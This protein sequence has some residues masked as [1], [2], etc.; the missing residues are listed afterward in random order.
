MDPSVQVKAIDAQSVHRITSGQVVIDLQTA[1]KELVEN[2]LDAKAT[3]IEVRFKEYGLRSIEVIDNGTGIAPQNYDSVGLKHHTSKLASF[4]DLTSVMTFGF[5]GEAISSLCALTESVTVTTAIAGAKF[6]TVLELDKDGSVRS[7]S[8]KVARQRGTTVSV[9]ELFKPLPVRRKELER[10]AKREF[11]KALHLLNAYA[12]VPCTKENQGVVFTVTNVTQGRKAVQLRTDGTMSLAA[13]V[14]SL[15]GP[16]TMENLVDLDLTFDVVTEAS[17]LR[18]RGPDSNVAA[19]NTIHVK[20]LISKFTVGGGRTGTDRQFFFI[21]GRPCNPTKVQKAFNEVYRTF[22]M[23][24]SPFIVAD[25]VIPSDSCDINVSPDKRTILIHSESNL[26]EALKHALAKAFSS[27]PSTF[28]LNTT[29]PQ[30]KDSKLDRRSSRKSEGSGD[31]DPPVDKPQVAAPVEVTA[32]SRPTSRAP[33]PVAPGDHSMIVEE[34]LIEWESTP[35]PA[36]PES[37][38]STRKTRNSRPRSPVASENAPANAGISTV[39]KPADSKPAVLSPERSLEEAASSGASSGRTPARVERIISA[40]EP[41]GRAREVQMVLDTSGA[42]WNLRRGTEAPPQKKARHDVG[43]GAANASGSSSGR[44]AR[45]NMREQLKDFARTGSQIVGRDDEE[46]D[47]GDD[48]NAEEGSED[49]KKDVDVDEDTSED[50]HISERTGHTDGGD[51]GDVV[52]VDAMEVDENEQGEVMGMDAPTEEI[53]ELQD[54]TIGSGIAEPPTD[55]MD[56]DIIDLTAD[57]IVVDLPAPS[58][59]SSVVPETELLV[60]DGP[61]KEIVR[62]ELGEVELLSFDID[63]VTRSWRNL[64][65]RLTSARAS[66]D[67]AVAAASSA[68]KQVLQKGAGVNAQGDASEALTRVIHK[69]DFAGM[70][71]VGQF[72]LGF[73]IARRRKERAD[74]DEESGG[75][76]AGMDMDDLFIVDQHAADEKYNFETLQQTTKIESQ[77]LFRPLPLELTAA[78]E[79]IAMENIDVLKQNG[80]EISV[81]VDEDGERSIKLVAQPVSKNTEFGLQDLEEIL[82]L[83]HDLPSGTM[84]RCSKARA[85]FAM[86]ACRK[87]TMVGA[88]LNTRQMTT[89]IRHMGTMEQPWN[90][91]HGRPTMRHLSDISALPARE[92]AVDWAQF[93]PS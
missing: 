82:H 2:S 12:L 33:S 55:A 52:E 41:K 25:F 68:E 63:R 27:A 3:N 84:V 81:A 76:G 40:D 65:D 9:T 50:V 20:G 22:N 56:V 10:N 8:G 88:A 78:D 35:E 67:A 1:V 38:P 29:Q 11:G 43:T 21:N 32:A 61:Q 58:H 15:W 34:T 23:N 70:D 83:M 77:M 5:R 51:E 62:T 73:I 93:V 17:V 91:P 89:I 26:V 75:G 19:S 87:S 60:S 64:S 18:R 80:F 13:S 86:R 14:S 74:F 47:G 6:G 37:Q 48:I 69:E 46:E 79:L 16:K 90:C 49:G 92:R 28:P 4:E 31:A 57:D 54:D 30:N 66:Q 72:N 44:S 42:S 85:M 59:S 71:I 24:Q 36:D 7:R 53:D 39:P 45:V